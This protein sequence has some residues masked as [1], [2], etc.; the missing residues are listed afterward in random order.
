LEQALA[1]LQGWTHT[2]P[3]LSISV[4]VS[5]RDLQDSN[6]C[7]RVKARMQHFGIVPGKLRLEIVESGLMQDAQSSIAVLHRLRDAGVE[8]SIDD[9]G[10]GYSSLAY[11]QQLPVSELKI[12]R[13]FV[14]DIDSKPGSLQL[15]KTMIEMGHGM[16]LMVT[17]EGIETAAERNTLSQLGCDVMQGYFGSRPLFGA[18]LQEWLTGGQ[19]TSA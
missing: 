11:L 19:A 3:H 9:F 2:H 6:F 14:T 13:S 18:Q 8:L 1:T 7:Q 5:T 12:D 10:T 16:G 15:T 4:N 17:A